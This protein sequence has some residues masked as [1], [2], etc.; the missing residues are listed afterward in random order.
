MA[1]LKTLVKS[2]YEKAPKIV[3]T[4][5]PACPHCR[6]EQTRVTTTQGKVRY[7][8]CDG[9]GHGAGGGNGETWKVV[10]PWA[11]PLVEEVAAFVSSMRDADIVTIDKRGDSI[12]FDAKDAAALVERFERYLPDVA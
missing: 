10:G 9:C 12:V 4:E 5:A 7:C 11:N 2:S 8:V 1:K 3:R 6:S